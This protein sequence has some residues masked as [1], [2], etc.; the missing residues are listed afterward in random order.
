[1]RADRQRR[2]HL[3]LCSAQHAEP[4]FG[5]V[6]DSQVRYQAVRLGRPGT[7][8]DAPLPNRGRFARP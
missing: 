5:A 3:G 8:G 1:M 2:Q 6:T 7:S 4:A